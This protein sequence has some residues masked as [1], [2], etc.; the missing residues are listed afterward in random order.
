MPP[1]SPD[2]VHDR[3]R[4]HGANRNIVH[5]VL[6]ILQAAVERTQFIPFHT[7]IGGLVVR[8]GEENASGRVQS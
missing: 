7:E 3:S 2:I 6:S 4:A 5:I 8:L 1:R